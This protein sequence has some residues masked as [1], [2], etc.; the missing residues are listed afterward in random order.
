MVG[1]RVA[2]HPMVCPASLSDAGI[3]LRLRWAG[4]TLF[5]TFRSHFLSVEMASLEFLARHVCHIMTHGWSA[6]CGA[7][8]G[9]LG[10]FIRCR[11]QVEM[12]WL[13]GIIIIT[14]QRYVTGKKKP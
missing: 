5:T 13:K 10:V 2:A 14:P 7:S 4:L 8:D 9:V 1:L 12:G 11:H 6:G 3:K